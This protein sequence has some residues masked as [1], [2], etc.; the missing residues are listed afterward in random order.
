MSMKRI[1]LILLLGM[2]V[3]TFGAGFSLPYGSGPDQVGFLNDKVQPDREELLPTGPLSFRMVAGKCWILDSVNGRL[4]LLDSD[5]KLAE[6]IS[7]PP[8][9]FGYYDDFAV[10]L[11][12]GKPTAF[13]VLSGAT[14]EILKLSPAGVVQEKFGG[15]GDEPGKFAQLFRIEIGASGNMYVADHGRQILAVLSPS[16]KVIREVHWEWSGFCLDPDENLCRLQWDEAGQVNHLLVETPEGKSVRKAPLRVGPHVNPNLWRVEKTG[17]VVL[18]FVQNEKEEDQ[19][20]I[21][22]CGAE[23]E[24]I[25]VTK[26]TP[27]KVMNR[28]FDWDGDVCLLGVAD[29]NEA[30]M[31]RFRIEKFDWK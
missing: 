31:G 14:Q 19:F 10:S 16:G 7:L 29:F 26:Y 1:A 8:Q 11:E 3:P 21:A 5:G 9:E 27:P 23:G 2:A 18:T 20:F 4:F 12:N 6:T 24:M 15:H 22:R 25:A 17:E 28:F 30:P 13:F